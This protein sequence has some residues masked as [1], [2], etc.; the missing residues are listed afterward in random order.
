[1]GHQFK[2]SMAKW[3][4]AIKIAFTTSEGVDSEDFSLKVMGIS[5]VFTLIFTEYSAVYNFSSS[6]KFRSF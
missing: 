1:M 4:L 6:G 3:N 2:V 5:V